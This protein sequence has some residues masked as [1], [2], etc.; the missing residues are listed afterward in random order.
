[1]AQETSSNLVG[2]QQGKSNDIFM[3][4]SWHQA[5]PGHMAGQCVVDSAASGGTGLVTTELSAGFK[6][7]L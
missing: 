5:I 2:S 7:I 1:M 6:T 3:D 4:V